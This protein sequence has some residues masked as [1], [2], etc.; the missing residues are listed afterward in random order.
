MTENQGTD[1]LTGDS[2]LGEG[3][4]HPRQPRTGGLVS[5][6]TKSGQQQGPARKHGM[7][8]LKSLEWG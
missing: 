3:A 2:K 5:S 1:N 8:G 7:G 4:G 6:L